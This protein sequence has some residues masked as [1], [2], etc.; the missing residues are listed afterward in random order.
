MT[1]LDNKIFTI[2]EVAY[3]KPGE[4][5]SLKAYT[6]EE[7]VDKTQLG[8]FHYCLLLIAGMCFMACI[9]EIT[10][11]GLIMFP[12]KCDLQF[13]LAQ[14]GLLGSAGFMGVTV[15]SHFM[16]FLADTWGRVR[17]LRTMLLISLCTSLISTMSANVWML[18]TFRFLTGVFI[19]GCQ[20]CVFTLVGEFHSSKTRVKHVAMVSIFLPSGLIYLPALAYF[21]LPLNINVHFL[22]INLLPWRVLMMANTL[23][24]MIALAGVYWLPESPKYL[25]SQGKHSESV[26]ILRKVYS[27]NSGKPK[28]TYPCN[29]VTLKDVG[30]DLSNKGIFGI[31]KLVWTQTISLFTRDRVFQTVNMCTITFIINLIAQ[32]TFMYFPIIINNLITHTESSLTVCQA[33]EV[34]GQSTSNLTLEEMCADPDS[35]NIQQYEFLTYIGCIFMLCYLFISAVIDY[36]GKKPLLMSWIALGGICSL[37]LHWINNIIL[38]MVALT[39]TVTIANCIGIMSTIALEF[40]P[41]NINAMGVS[42]VMMVGRLGAV[43]GTNMVGPLL[44]SYCET[45]FFTYGGAITFICVLAFFLPRGNVK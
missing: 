24:S 6:Y 25:L 32:G 38:V 33:F 31:L 5:K 1:K 8:K 21:I 42:F 45:L 35:M 30:S 22:G 26:E 19:S 40:Y 28:N 16:G 12:A 13:T 27:M 39:F 29:I 3:L 37:L 4:E 43:V 23:P 34:A 14:Q 10:G 11:L 9:T 17:S 15:S 2:S 44:F 20:A 7:A 41:T 18:F 36:T